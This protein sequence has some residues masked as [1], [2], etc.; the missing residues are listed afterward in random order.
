MKL[1]A[2]GSFFVMVA[3]AF[4]IGFTSAPR[5]EAA[6]QAATVVSPGTSTALATG[7]SATAFSLA[8][9]ANAACKGDSADDGYRVQS[10]MVPSS[11]DP[12]TLRFGSTGPVPRGTG[13]SFR[14]PLYSTST[15]PFVNEQT[16]NVDLPTD[17]AAIVSVPSFA[18]SVFAQGDIPP[19]SYNI[20]LACTKGTGDLVV[21]DLWNVK[22]EVATA[23]SDPLGISWTAT[24]ASAAGALTQ[25]SGAAGSSGEKSAA[26]V[27][28]ASDARSLAAN[29]NESQSATDSAQP[30]ANEPTG[31]PPSLSFPALDALPAFV[32]GLFLAGAVAALFLVALFARASFVHVRRS[33]L[34]TA[35]AA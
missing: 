20:G 21:E 32:R 18:L 30:R 8:L 27:A 33:A 13:A 4:A 31:A 5:A 1:L 17:R 35:A 28:A 26:P 16:A 22:L 7:G 34:R 3:G 19:G 15:S 25:T 11:V 9:P 24:N 23:A 14:Q 2:R 29:A 6:A 10:Y 12:S